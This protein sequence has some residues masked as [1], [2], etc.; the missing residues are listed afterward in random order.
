MVLAHSD[1]GMIMEA[2]SNR[3]KMLRA[4]EKKSSKK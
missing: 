1:H 4:L 2:G 3:A